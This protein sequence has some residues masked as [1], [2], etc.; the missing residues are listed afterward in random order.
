MS[1]GRSGYS[2]WRDIVPVV[3]F[4]L[5]LLITFSTREY[6]DMQPNL[7]PTHGSIGHQIDRLPERGQMHDQ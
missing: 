3:V 6:S 2:I 5:A 7:V 4:G 1:L